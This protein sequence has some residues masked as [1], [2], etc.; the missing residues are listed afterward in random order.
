MPWP[1]A[2]NIV[3]SQNLHFMQS[4]SVPVGGVAR[5]VGTTKPKPVKTTPRRKRNVTHT[6][7]G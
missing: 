2:K 6:E 3:K 7:G 5:T 1:S 4:V